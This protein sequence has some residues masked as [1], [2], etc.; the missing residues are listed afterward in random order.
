MTGRVK[1]RAGLDE[2]ERRA[3]AGAV[4]RTKPLRITLTRRVP[5]LPPSP[6]GRV[7]GPRDEGEWEG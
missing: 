2:A 4:K 3:E 6:D 5:R 1:R 7:N